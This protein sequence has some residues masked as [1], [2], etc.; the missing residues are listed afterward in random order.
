MSDSKKPKIIAVVGPTASSKS[1]LALWLA[2]QLGGVLIGT[3]SMQVY[4]MLDIGTSKPSLQ[5]RQLVPHYQLDLVD[6]DGDYSAGA[7]ERDLDELLPQLLKQPTVPILVG[8]TGLY[9]RAAVYGISKIPNVPPELKQQIEAWHHEQGLA[10]CFQRLQETDPQAA[11]QLHPNDTTRILRALEVVLYTGESLLHFQQ[12]Q[13]FDTLKYSLFTVGYAFERPVLYERINQRTYEMLRSG[14]VAEVEAL[15]KL[16]PPHLKPLH[17]I[18]YHQ[19]LQFLQGELD[20]ETMIEK[21]QQKTR[22][23]AKRQ[24]TW[25]HK[26]TQIHWYT[27]GSE[28]QILRDIMKFLEKG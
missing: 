11:R 13:P 14:W 10:Y 20:R 2:Q 18:G 7:Y 5:E 19:I 12:Q 21:I 26:E 28:N 17:A 16:Y 15:L 4:R 25:F 6:P 9:Y 3:D 27:K 8:G 22:N 23:Y 24:L 1:D